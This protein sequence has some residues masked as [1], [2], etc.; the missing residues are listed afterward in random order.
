MIAIT[1]VADKDDKFLLPVARKLVHFIA[2]RP[3][4]KASLF[5]IQD[6]EQNEP[7]L[8]G[9]NHLI[10]LEKNRV[11][12]DI[13]KCITA[14]QS[15]KGVYWGVDCTLGVMFVKPSEGDLD[16]LLKATKLL[17]DDVIPLLPKRFGTVTL[18]GFASMPL[19]GAFSL[20]A[21]I[22]GYALS[23]KATKDEAVRRAQYEYGILWFIKDHYDNFLKQTQ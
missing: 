1:V 9:K 8:S 12:E 6:Y 20:L 7:V 3:E 15:S 4:A 23:F 16:D 17:R 11:S 19:L 22:G 10:F 13:S 2:S 21:M 5:S 18:L 14:W